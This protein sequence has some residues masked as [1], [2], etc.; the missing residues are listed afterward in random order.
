MLADLSVIPVVPDLK[1]MPPFNSDIT[2]DDEFVSKIYQI[3][4]C[5]G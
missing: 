1:Q 5:D 4:R 3:K 2:L